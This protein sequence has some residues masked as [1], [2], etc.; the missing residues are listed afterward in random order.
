MNG[1]EGLDWSDL[2]A[3]L[4]VA[5]AGS[6]S[7]AAREGGASQPTLTLR[8]AGLEARLGAV[9]MERGAA[10]IR[11]TDAGREAMVRAEAMEDAAARLSLSAARRGRGRGVTGVVRITAS[12]IVTTYLLPPLIAD[13][14]D[15][16]PGLEIELVAS[17]QTSNLLR[18]EA[19]IA[20]RMYRPTQA[21][22]VARKVGMLA[23]G[24]YAAPAYLDRHGTPETPEDLSR[25]RLLGYDRSDLVRRGFA[26][27]G[28]PQPREA[29][30]LRTDDQ[31]AYWE[32][33]AAGAG[34][35]GGQVA[36]AARDARVRRVLPQAPIPPLELWIAAH[37]ELRASAR[38]RRVFDHLAEGLG[39][40]VAA[41]G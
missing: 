28:L 30:R 7:A 17:D 32:A 35:G 33:V 4:A 29:F 21:D 23:I 36:V 19:D 22:L 14:L 10:G 41:A 8:I 16:E 26:A 15:A 20:L 25:H 2:Q 13:L 5:R 12:R 1:P 39:R 9:L 27:A 24:L 6:F 3:L 37:A 34:I 18:R 38:V 40:V 31:V 11:L